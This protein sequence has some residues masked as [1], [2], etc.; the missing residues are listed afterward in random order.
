MWDMADG[1]PLASREFRWFF[2]GSAEDH[3]DLKKWFEMIE[4][5]KKVAAVGPPS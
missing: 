2:E 4:P 5:V 3:L 1:I